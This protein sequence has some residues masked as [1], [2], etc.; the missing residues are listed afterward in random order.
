[1]G[2]ALLAVVWPAVHGSRSRRG[3]VFLAAVA[4]LAAQLFFEGFRWQLVPLY[5]VVLAVGIG[6]LVSMDRELPWWRRVSRGALGLIGLGMMTLPAVALPVPTLPPLAGSLA[7]GTATFTI[8][9]PD[10]LEAYG[11]Q[12]DTLPRRIAVQVWYP[13]ESGGRTTPWTQDL[14]LLGPRISRRLGYPSFFLSHTRYTTARARVGATPLPGAFPVVMYSHDYGDFRSV[15]VNQA[16]SLASRGYFVIAPDHA[17]AALVTRLDNGQVMELDTEALPTTEDRELLAIRQRELLET[18]TEDLIG[19]L[20]LMADGRGPFGELASH[21][22]LGSVGAYGRGAGGGAVTWFCLI[23]ARCKGFLGMNPW[24]APVP[25]RIVATTVNLPMLFMRTSSEEGTEND[26][27]LRGIAER[28]EGTSY[29]LMVEG[30]EPNDFVVAPVFSPINERLGISGPIPA[31]E[32]LAIVDRYLLGFFDH[33]LLGSGTA[34][35]DNNPF[36]EVT[37]EILK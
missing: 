10:R 20:D 36:P 15:A 30:A 22:D 24:V 17:Y 29:W 4:G 28:N 13:A 32:M 16:E 18:M 7:V 31:G 9:F 5:I 6:D 27:R 2:I 25:D 14:D 19:I 11:P 37:L 8:R 23:D 34:A 26:G 35:I 33:A 1:M 12:P 3:I 21:A